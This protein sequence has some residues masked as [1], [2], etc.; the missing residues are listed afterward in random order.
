MSEFQTNAVR[1]FSELS[2]NSAGADKLGQHGFILHLAT[3]S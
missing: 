1:K 3:N 2:G